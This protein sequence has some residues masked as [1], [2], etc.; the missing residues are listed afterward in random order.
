MTS[1]DLGINELTWERH[2]P[3][4]K[5]AFEGQLREEQPGNSVQDRRLRG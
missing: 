4:R 2:R 3:L 1:E 5:G